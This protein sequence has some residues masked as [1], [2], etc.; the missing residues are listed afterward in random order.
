MIQALNAT[1]LPDG[2]GLCPH[3]RVGSVQV[4]TYA[5]A[6][7]L[8]M[9]AGL[10]LFRWNARRA[11]IAPRRP[12]PI[13]LAALGGGLLGAK[14]PAWLALLPEWLQ[15][16][17]SWP[18]FFSGRTIVGGLVGGFLAVWLVKR[19]LGINTR[20]GNLLAP[21]LALGMALGRVGCLLAGCCYGMPTTL[22]WGVN[23]GDGVPRHPTQ[24]YEIIV[25][26]AA[27]ALLQRQVLRA[28][29]GRLLSGFLAAYF[30]G[31]FLEE[32]IRP[33]GCLAGLTEFQ[34]I[35]LVGLA[36]LGVKEWLAW[37]MTVRQAAH[38]AT[39]RR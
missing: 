2:W 16:R 33:D 21:S 32:Y 7:A 14:L 12:L 30:A 11:G 20:Y 26:L 6:M 17:F 8:A 9:L 31:R 27:F 22:P 19:L 24:V 39:M 18:A 25:L 15:G 3:L 35:C 28:A 23:F 1:G 38:A 10:L 5:L 34:W 4:T 29:P 13:L 36:L 37:R